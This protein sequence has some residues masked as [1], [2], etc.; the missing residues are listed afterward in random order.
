MS[1]IDPEK[2]MTGLMKSMGVSPQDFMNFIQS[3][4]REIQE[5]RADRLA[6]KPASIKAYQEL[7]AR[8]DQID[9]KLNLILTR[10]DSDR[11]RAEHPK[12]MEAIENERRDING[13]G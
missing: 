11:F 4:Q 3:V 9:A 2:I 8:M 7:T 10:L 12:L 1:W 13:H 5:M 6:F